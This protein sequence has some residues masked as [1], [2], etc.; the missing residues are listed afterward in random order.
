MRRIE[1]KNIKYKFKK[2]FTFCVLT[3]SLQHQFLFSG[4]THSDLN[5]VENFI[6]DET[7]TLGILAV[8]FSSISTSTLINSNAVYSFLR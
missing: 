7:I 2:K 6:Y 3:S 1:K 8:G 5:S 4:E